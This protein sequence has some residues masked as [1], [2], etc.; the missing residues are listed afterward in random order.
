MKYFTPDLLARFGSR[1]DEIAD[2]ANDEWEQLSKRYCEHLKTIYPDLPSSARALADGPPLHD[3]RV[4]DIGVD[5]QFHRLAVHLVPEGAPNKRIHVEYHLAGVPVLVE[6]SEDR[7]EHAPLEWLYDE[8]DLL[9]GTGSPVWTHSI[10][11]TRG[12]ELQA[13][14]TE[15]VVRTYRLVT[16]PE[17][18]PA[19]TG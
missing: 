4:V 10:L 13:P 12:L 9:P 17:K 3:A 2:A 16:R 7:N 6:H 11:F 18:A 1:D 5:D 19:L 14:F 8:F 15:M